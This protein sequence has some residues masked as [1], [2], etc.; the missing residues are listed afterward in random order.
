MAFCFADDKCNSSKTGS[1]SFS[2]SFISKLRSSKDP[3]A[4][5][6]S[7]W[8]NDLY[9][10]LPVK[11]HQGNDSRSSDEFNDV[12]DLNC[13]AKD[14]AE[15][16]SCQN[17]ELYPIEDREENDHDSSIEAKDVDGNCNDSTPSTELEIGKNDEVHSAIDAPPKENCSVC[18]LRLDPPCANTST[19]EEE[20]LGW[21]VVRKKI[22]THKRSASFDWPKIS[23]VQ[24]A[25]RRSNRNAAIHPDSKSL[26][27]S[28]NTKTNSESDSG[29]N[30]MLDT[31]SIQD[32]AFYDEEGWP[33]KELDSLQEKYSS[34]CRLFRYEELKLATSN[35]SPGLFSEHSNYAQISH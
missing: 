17:G 7:C 34:V 13:G 20:R 25:M 22:V 35:F 6:P 28:S 16:L 12:H 5:L 4:D 18:N 32:F 3:A 30:F 27:S 21:P 10:I 11:V 1:R 14:S 33:P 9:C 31:D 26:K 24:W 8:D 2:T 23:V 19:R 15:L 29:S